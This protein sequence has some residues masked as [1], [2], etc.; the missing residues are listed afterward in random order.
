MFLRYALYGIFHCEILFFYTIFRFFY[1]K[2]LSTIF[3]AP[4]HT[5]LTPIQPFHHLV[6]TSAQ[7]AWLGIMGAGTL[8]GRLEQAL[9]SD[10]YVGFHEGQLTLVNYSRS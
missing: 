1:H 3:P 4:K 2:F 7:P 8:C 10:A 6:P 9:R 5:V